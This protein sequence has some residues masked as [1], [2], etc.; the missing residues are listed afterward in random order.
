MQA[1]LRKT[2]SHFKWILWCQSSHQTRATIHFLILW[3]LNLDKQCKCT[4]LSTGK[5][6]LEVHAYIKGGGLCVWKFHIKKV[7]KSITLLTIQGNTWNTSMWPIYLVPFPL[8]LWPKSFHTLTF[9][10]LVN[11]T[12]AICS[13]KCIIVTVIPLFSWVKSPSSVFISPF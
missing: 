7:Y 4:S 1:W 6:F 2:L 3:Y 11:L 5:H 8:Q 9:W 12:N 13:K 10:I